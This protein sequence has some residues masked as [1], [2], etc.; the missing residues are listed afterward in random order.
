VFLGKLYTRESFQAEKES[1]QG[2]ILFYKEQCRT[3]AKKWQRPPENVDAYCDTNA[4]RFQ[5]SYDVLTSDPDRYFY[6]ITKRKKSS[7]WHNQPPS[8]DPPLYQPWE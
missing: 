8:S 4:A 1:L 5:R 2:Q 3:A 6:I 7:A